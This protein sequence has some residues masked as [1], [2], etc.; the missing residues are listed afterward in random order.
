MHTKM[1]GKGEIS[2]V[3]TKA[4]NLTQVNRI[5]MQYTRELEMIEM[6]INHYIL[7]TNSYSIKQ[8][9]ILKDHLY[10]FLFG[11]NYLFVNLV[12]QLLNMKCIPTFEEVVAIIQREESLLTMLS[13]YQQTNNSA[14]AAKHLVRLYVTSSH[15]KERKSTS[16]FSQS[17]KRRQG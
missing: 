15:N 7:V 8:S 12:G 3:T 10:R 11:L 6:K 17:S 5:V 16:C 2:C 9:Y 1:N 4:M 13:E 14:L